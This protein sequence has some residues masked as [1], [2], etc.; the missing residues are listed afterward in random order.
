MLASYEALL[1]HGSYNWCGRHG[2]QADRR[3]ARHAQPH[4]Q[5]GMV[6][7]AGFICVTHRPARLPTWVLSAERLASA[8]ACSCS[9]FSLAACKVAGV[10]ARTVK[11]AMKVAPGL[12]LAIC[13]RTVQ[14]WGTPPHTLPC[15][16]SP[17]CH[18]PAPHYTK[19]SLA[20]QRQKLPHLQ[21]AVLRLQIRHQLAQRAHFLRAEPR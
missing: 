8:A 14:A 20:F 5:S 17:H 7:P 6:V 13:L 16:R 11:Q 4:W 21:L 3:C 19:K 10:A 12:E 1:G 9:V 15:S 18:T 2:R